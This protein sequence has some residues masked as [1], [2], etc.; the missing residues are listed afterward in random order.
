MGVRVQ[1]RAVR[2]SLIR[3]N[4]A[5]AAHRA[6]SHRLHQR[7]YSVAGPNSLWH[8][9]GNHKLI[10]IQIIAFCLI[11]KWRMVIHGGICGFSRLVVFLQ[12]SDNN[13]S[14]T[15][16]DQFVQA[17]A[18]YGV[19]SRIRCDYR[20][21]NNAVCLFMNIY[22]GSER[23]SAIRGRSVH[24]QQIER[25]WG[26]LWR[27]MTNVY[28]QLFSFLENDGIIDCTNELHLWALHYVYLPRINRDL[29]V[30][31]EQWNNHG[32]RTVGHRTPCQIFV[33]GC[34]QRQT[35]PLTA[36]AEIFGSDTAQEGA[37][38]ALPALNWQ[39]VVTVPANQFSP[40]H[41]Q[42]QQLQGVDTLAGPIGSLATD[43]LQ[44]VIDILEQ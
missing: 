1:R 34:L 26:D 40:S 33:Q 20:G 22:R 23:E 25:L 10:R 39:D 7:T 37:V 36:M 32:L 29:E 9:D 43:T 28:H 35:Q 21:E 42:M 18:R 27:G 3:V 31:R 2:E 44:S 17:T 38:A 19:P 16:F 12:A 24:N 11:F 4:P 14:S 5:G 41:A 30:F 13:R 6:L 15:V 8:I